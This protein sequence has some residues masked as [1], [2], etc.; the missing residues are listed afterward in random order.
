MFKFV[1]EYH[2]SIKYRSYEKKHENKNY[3]TTIIFS[4]ES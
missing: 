2:I 4:R 1:L 3:Y